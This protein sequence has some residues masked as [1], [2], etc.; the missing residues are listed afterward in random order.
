MGRCR[1][2]GWLKSLP[3]KYIITVWGQYAGFLHLEP[4]QD[5]LL[6]MATVADGLVGGNILSLPKAV[7]F[8]PHGT[9]TFSESD[10]SFP[11]L[12]PCFG[13]FV[14]PHGDIQVI[15]M[16]FLLTTGNLVCC[17]QHQRRWPALSILTLRVPTV[18]AWLVRCLHREV[19]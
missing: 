3:L 15:F 4:P 17:S 12:S 10:L 19:N 13:V 11:W 16:R 5:G 8:C 9:L 1:S 18:I 6:G 7:F 2:L 14:F